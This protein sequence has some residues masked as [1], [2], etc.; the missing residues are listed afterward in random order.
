MHEASFEKMR[1]ALSVYAPASLDR[2]RVL[3]LGSGGS[4]DSL[5]YRSLFPS[6]RFEYLGL[7]LAG[8]PN[9]DIVVGDAYDW[10]ELDDEQFDLVVSGQMLEHSPYFWITAAEIA[11][12]LKEGGITIVIAPSAGFAHRYPLDCW[13]F[14]PDSWSAICRYVGLELL[15]TYRE[16]PS[17]R[18]TIPGT[19]WGDAMMIARKPSFDDAVDRKR[20]LDRLRA[21]VDTR[22]DFPVP[23]PP[24]RQWGPAGRC[25]EEAQ[26]IDTLHVAWRP[27]SLAARLQKSFR[28]WK[29]RPRPAAVLRRI[30]A[31][32]ARVSL[33]RGRARVAWP[34]AAASAP[35]GREGRP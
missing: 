27:V 35:D 2:L 12:V 15:E 20:F 13:R 3:D 30:E 22:V 7:D 31:H 28:R 4:E 34:P 5:T 14:Y 29:T 16:K 6:D 24:V 10:R 8:G 1:A 17:W 23:A 18:K 21:V 25:Y 11:R 32:D 19:Y 33:A 26:Q 9:V